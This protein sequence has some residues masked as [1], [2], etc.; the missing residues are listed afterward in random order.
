MFVEQMKLAGVARA[1]IVQASTCYGHDNSYV[2]DS[3][4]RYADKVAAVC[5][6]D[7]LIPD[8]VDVIKHWQSRGMVGLR[9]FMGGSTAAIDTSW[10]DDPRSFAAW[11]YSA[12]NRI[13]V[14]LQMS[15]AGFDRMENII[16]QFPNII[17]LLDHLAM[18]ELTDGYPYE[19][20]PRTFGDLKKGK[21][22]SASF[23][24]K[25]VGEYG[26]SRIAWGS[27]YPN[28]PGSLK[29]ILAT[30]QDGTAALPEADKEWIFSKTAQ[31]L[32]PTLAIK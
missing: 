31:Q 6:A 19:C 29:E 9:L 25:L 12:Q 10:L 27:N 23:F 7:F 1:A 21:A 32:Y 4:Q 11:D 24:K 20:T 26:A 8:A 22:D 30:A 14:C 18:A 16:R 2:A 17:L 3:C 13:P 28:S 15:D 5:S